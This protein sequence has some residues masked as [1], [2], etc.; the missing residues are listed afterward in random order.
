MSRPAIAA[1]DLKR[2]WRHTDRAAGKLTDSQANRSGEILAA[3]ITRAASRQTYYTIRFL[4]DRDRVADAYRAY[5]YFRWVDDWLDMQVSLPLERLAF[6]ERQQALIDPCSQRALPHDLTAE[7]TML[8][9]LLRADRE[10]NGNNSGLQSYMRNMMAVMAFDA[11]RRG[12]L[13]SSRELDDYTRYLATGVTEAMHYFIGHD[14]PS[15]QSDSRYLAVAAAHITHMLRDT[16]EDVEAGYF[17]V[18]SEFLR[19]RRLNP[20]DIENDDYREWVKS[21]VELARAY[22][23]AGEAYLSQ[24]KHTRCR[25]AGY[26]YMARFMGVLDTIEGEGYRLRPSYPETK[27]L[28]AVLR[29]GVSALHA[30]TVIPT[31]AGDR[32]NL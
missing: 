29:I 20:C 3:N 6:V 26:M 27:S 13:I 7:E 17:N 30:L 4:A 24:I 22:F 8:L 1:P 32:E 28:R 23:K 15:P 9:S 19:T 5:A 12:R 2:T 11:N 25:V 10:H 21:R 14:S 31:T 18:P 16:Y